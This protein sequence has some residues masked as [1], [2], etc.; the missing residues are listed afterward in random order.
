VR[1]GDHSY[2]DRQARSALDTHLLRG[3]VSDGDDRASNDHDDYP[4]DDRASDDGA[5]Y[6]PDAI[7]GRST[8]WPASCFLARRYAGRSL[9]HAVRRTELRRTLQ[10]HG[11]L[12]FSFRRE[13][14]G[15]GVI[16]H[17]SSGPRDPS[18]QSDTSGLTEIGRLFRAKL[19]QLREEDK[20][21][22]YSATPVRARTP[23]CPTQR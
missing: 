23:T 13:V 3:Y 20:T 4:T 12:A 15:A 5:A 6:N 18:S 1:R 10:Q 9:L 2:A 21:L 14:L 7:R 22:A 17:P 8:R 16:A 19:R 11:R